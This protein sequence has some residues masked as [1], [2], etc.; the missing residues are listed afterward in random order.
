[1]INK[2]YLSLLIVLPT[3]ISAQEEIF[4]LQYKIRVNG[5]SCGEMIFSLKKDSEGIFEASQQ[6]KSKILFFHLDQ[7]EVTRFEKKEMGLRPISY[8]FKRDNG[9][10][11]YYI[12][13]FD[14]SN[15]DLEQNDRLSLQF[16]L[17]ENLATSK[18]LEVQQLNVV[19]DKSD[20]TIKPLI[21][22]EKSEIK[23]SFQIKDRDHVIVFDKNH[24]LLPTKF[25]QKRGAFVFEGTLE[26]SNV[27]FY[28]W[29]Y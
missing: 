3:I 24:N 27:D 10:K 8:T 29:W 13:E 6:W 12:Y 7:S 19:D 23:V 16:V 21:E 20:Y 14:R 1:M 25:I 5:L 9:N 17:M 15:Y 11:K 28:K 4:K 26:K 18:E 2:L 22:Y